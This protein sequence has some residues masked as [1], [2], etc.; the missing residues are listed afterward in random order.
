MRTHIYIKILCVIFIALGFRSGDCRLLIFVLFMQNFMGFEVWNHWLSYNFL[1]MYFCRLE[2]FI[3]LR[4]FSLSELE[5]WSHHKPI[6]EKIDTLYGEWNLGYFL[7]GMD[8]QA[9]NWSSF[10]WGDQAPKYAWW[11]PSQRQE[12][13]YRPKCIKINLQGN[14]ISIFLCVNRSF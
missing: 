1:W 11:D 3:L 12:P 8:V 14:D 5:S 6:S 7:S 10:F 2:S 4:I 13:P 9:S